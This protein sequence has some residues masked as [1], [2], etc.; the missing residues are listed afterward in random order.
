[1]RDLTRRRFLKKSAAAGVAVGCG[2]LLPSWLRADEK[3]ALPILARVRGPA[4]EAVQEAVRL[5]GG[6]ETFVTQG[7][8][9]LLKPNASFSSPPE[10]GATTSTEVVRAVAEMCL[11]AG[12]ERIT[13]FDHPLRAPELCLQQTGLQESVAELEQVK[14]ILAT[15]QRY[16]EPVDVPGGQ[17]LQ[18]VEVAKEVLR[19]DVIINLPVAKSHSATGVS[20]GMKNLMGLIWDR[21]FFHQATHLHRAIAELCGVIRPDLTILDATRALVTGG[22]GGPGD[23][24]NLNMILA[25]VDPVAVDAHAVGLAPWLNRSMTP[26]QVTCIVEGSALGLGRMHS[27]EVYLKE[28]DLG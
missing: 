9:V 23:V 16:F 10:W 22:P 11:E 26:E 27:D 19:A 5:L 2:A 20:L 13:V 8:R 25:S 15:A 6:M 18:Q 14:V 21:G 7:Q 24:L 1:M 28:V 17:A 4:A 12:A 3:E